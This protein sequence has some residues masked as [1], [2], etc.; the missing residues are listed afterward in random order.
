MGSLARSWA[1]TAR[2]YGR[3]FETSGAARLYALEPDGLP[4]RARRPDHVRPGWTYTKDYVRN[5]RRREANRVRAVEHVWITTLHMGR[6]LV[7]VVVGA[8]VAL[9]PTRK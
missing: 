5:G 3:R 4:L 6:G 8:S 9:R 2:V 7:C 1:A